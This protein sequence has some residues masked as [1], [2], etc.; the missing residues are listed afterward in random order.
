MAVC[1]TVCS[2]VPSLG[3]IL[4]VNEAIVRVSNSSLDVPFS[5]G[6]HDVHFHE[7]FGS[8]IDAFQLEE[9]FLP[10]R[11]AETVALKC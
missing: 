8:A 4:L 7:S 2:S 5:S 10:F 6:V 9:L 3:Q 11:N 1:Q